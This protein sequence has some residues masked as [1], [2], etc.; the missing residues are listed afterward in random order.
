MVVTDPAGLPAR[1]AWEIV[2]LA[3]HAGRPTARDYINLL[4]TSF[5]ELHGDR[6]TADSPSIVGGIAEFGG[7]PI[8]VVAT[9]KGHSTREL[10]QTNFGMAGPEGYRKALR[11]FRLAEKLSLPVVTLVDTPG[12]Y[13]GVEAEERGQAATIA[14][15]IL[16][17]TGL[18]VPVVSVI[19]GE[20]GSGGALALAVGDRLLMFENSVYSVISP[21]GCAA[22]LWD[23]TAATRAAAALRLTAGDLLRLGIADGVIPE[24]GAGAHT[25]LVAA[26]NLLGAAVLSC[27]AELDGVPADRLIAQRRKR[28]R[29]IG[30]PAQ[31]GGPA[32][33]TGEP[34]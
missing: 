21:E 4:A 31:V 15:N 32:W 11:L 33:T 29:D 8:M 26:A 12:A 23:S 17:L 34:R 22:I 2:G 16:A 3:R 10:L 24:P 6:Q 18:R 27:L 28:L 25:D 1:D 9:Q 14:E 7:V 13:P 20:G 5:L 19:T 30:T